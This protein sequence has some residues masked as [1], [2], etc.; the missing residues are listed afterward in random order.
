MRERGVSITIKFIA[1][2]ASMV[3]CGEGRVFG[4]EPLTKII[5]AHAANNPRV[6][7]LWIAKEQGIFAKYGIDAEPIFIRNSSIAIGALIAGNIQ[8]GFN[9]GGAQILSAA[10]QGVDIKIIAT[11]TTRLTHDLVARPGIN[12]PKDLRGKRVGVQVLGGSL[13]L[14]AMLALEAL[15]LEPSRDDVRILVI[16]DQTVLTQALESGVIDAAPLDGA[17]SQR[18]K[19]QGFPILIE[20]YRAN[21]QTA[22]ATAVLMRSYM[23]AQPVVVENVMKGLIEGLAFTLSPRH[24]AAVI[25]TI[26]RRL[27]INNIADA[28]EGYDG[29]LK[30]MELKPY[31]TARSMQNMQRFVKTQNP[32]IA[33]VKV[34]DVLDARVI[35]KL[36]ESGFIDEVYRSYGVVNK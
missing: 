6:A 19:K 12:A 23:Q 5:I 14:T 7:P 34:E 21:I 28:E 36:D 2:V 8:V 3:M 16:G 10:A 30:A 11:F 27:K 31:P 26:M 25:K 1:L 29:L 33:G 4:A 35:K 15:G 20:L 24:K 17:F 18:L 13:W 32:A 22:S 9:A